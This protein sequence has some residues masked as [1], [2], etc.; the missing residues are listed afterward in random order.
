[1]EL[2]SWLFWRIQ[3]SPLKKFS[4]KRFFDSYL[5][6]YDVD[7]MWDALVQ[8]W[9]KNACSVNKKVGFF[10]VA[11]CY[12]GIFLMWLWFVTSC[13][14]AW[15]LPWDDRNI[16]E[17]NKACHSWFV[18]PINYAGLTWKER[19]MLL[20]PQ[21]IEILIYLELST[22]WVFTKLIKGFVAFLHGFF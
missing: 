15:D 5:S 17:P 16:M 10:G 13:L 4:F 9:K 22:S 12:E 14:F 11:V 3:S 19:I 18:K 7:G 21:D 20:P 2:V 1:M 8:I 6:K